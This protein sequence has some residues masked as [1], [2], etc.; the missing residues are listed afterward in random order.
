MT[1]TLRPG[2][3]LLLSSLLASA[4]VGCNAESGATG[5]TGATTSTNP[6]GGKD[7][8]FVSDNPDGSGAHNKGGGDA[9]AGTS[10]STG[11][12][13]NGAGGA[14]QGGDAAANR[15][16][17]EA[18][19][20]QVKDGKLYALSQYS[21]L[22]II[23]ISQKD[24]LKILGRWQSLGQPFEMYLRDG[25]V[26]AEFN[27]WGDYIYDDANQ[28]WQ[29]VTSSRIEALDV[30]NPAD[31][32]SVGSFKMPGILSD[33]RTVGDVLYA[34][35]YEDGYCWNCKQTP[36]TT[37]TSLAVADPKKIHVVD[38]LTYTADDPNSYGWWKKSITVNQAR[39]YVA[40][41]EWNG[42]GEGHSTIQVVDISDPG[43]KLVQGAEVQAAGQIDSRWQM[44]EYQ[45]VLRVV[46]QP[47][48]WWQNGTPIVQTFSVKSSFD[49]QPL[50][51]LTMKLPQPEVLQAARF[52]GPH[53]YA[54]TA[55]QKDPLF[56]LD[57]SDPKNP[58]QV[59]SIEMPGFVYY[60]EPRGDRLYTIGFDQGNQEGSLN[61][62]LFDVSD[63][64]QPKMLERV[65]FGGDW[66]NLAEDQDRIQKAFTFNDDLGL[67]MVPFSAWNYSQ[68][69][70]GYYGCSSYISGI[71]LIDFGKDTLAKRGVAPAKG[72][73][74]RA[75]VHD[76]RL[77]GM[78]DSEVSTFD[79]A[80]RDAPKTTASLPIATNVTQSVVV[81]DKLARL[82][83][84]WWTGAAR[85]DVV[86]LAKPDQTE[87]I[88]TLDLSSLDPVNDSCWGWS[89]WTSNAFASGSTLTLVRSGWD[90]NY[91]QPTTRLDLID[92]SDAT[93]P[94]PI[95]HVDLD[96]NVYSWGYYA[97]VSSG[98]SMVQV[99][100]TVVFRAVPNPVWYDPQNP[101]KFEDASLEIVDL[102]DPKKPVRSSVKLPSGF[103]HTNLIA[104]G[105]DIV[106]SHWVPDA[107]DPTKVRFYVDR[108]DVSNP[109]APVV[110]A[111]VNVPGALVAVDGPSGRVM[112]LD[113]KL[114]EIDDVLAQDCYMAFS[115]VAS[116]TPGDKNDP[117]A[118]QQPGTCFGM[119]RTFKLA[120]VDAGKATLIS[121]TDLPDNAWFG[122][123][124]LGDDRV[125]GVQNPSYGYG[126]GYA[127]GGG[128]ANYD[129]AANLN[130]PKLFVVG[131]LREGKLTQATT[132]LQANDWVYVAGVLGKKAVTTGYGQP[133]IGLFDTTDMAAP[134]Y[135]VV[136][137]LPSWISDVKVVGE[138]A[139]CSMSFWGVQT[140]DLTK[141]ID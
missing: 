73:A 35:T 60:I 61:A 3:A 31:I 21:G 77:F 16:I 86:P 47:G 59:G 72:W 66:S 102:A 2:F 124:T 65:N 43:G 64:T 76:D 81:G 129:G 121:Q 139:V 68:D 33:S 48:M 87:P 136:Q 93:K 45:G 15:A 78:S 70:N 1:R 116:W 23:D 110:H 95:G 107:N 62:S 17:A 53:A 85:L 56:T 10:T 54:I 38:Q 111:P 138:T 137:E 88:G 27:S 114:I 36:N 8:G 118:W 42:Q 140:V 14:S 51:S 90:Y 94:T 130:G 117:N 67:L 44:D 24:H 109:T 131:G 50:G 40:G 100:S 84:D 125:F 63:M 92:L 37:V 12:G 4:L 55:V 46:S 52:D 49:V 96:F 25:M 39:M 83:S 9:A 98:A 19:I 133:A 6:T 106:L 112:T 108:V 123:L 5:S 122:N 74:R 97:D 82:A 41:V 89:Y 13:E 128:Y 34:V 141:K 57:L 18:D 32:K 99:G 103:G 127:D 7:D 126:Y 91:S 75:F 113:Y 120:D 22:S 132:Q 28:G 20:V 11:T 119:H 26:Y 80:N 30:T 105:H 79:I 134:K 29:W 115:W 69:Q 101:S 135:G 58:K 71:Q 104:D